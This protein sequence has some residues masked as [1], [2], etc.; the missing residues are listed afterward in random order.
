MAACLLSPL[1]FAQDDSAKVERYLSRLGLSEMRVRH[2]EREVQQGGESRDRAA[3]KL[4]DAY[5]A[6]L[7]DAAEDQPRFDRLKLQIDKLLLTSP[8]AGTPALQV[9]LLQAEFQRG[10]ALIT[11]WI[12]DPRDKQLLSRAADILGPLATQLESKG[13]ELS[14][15]VDKLA[16]GI[17]AIKSED[18]RRAADAE[19]LRL[20]AVV[21]RVTFYTGWSR[22]YLG[23]TKQESMSAQPE[24]A[25]A[26]ALFC[27]VLGVSDEKEYADVEDVSS[28]G[29]E[30]TWRARTALGL[31]LTE[32]GLGRPA[33]A[34]RCFSWLQHASAPAGLRDQGSFWQLQGLLNA[35]NL[36]GAAEFAA[37]K[38]E[39]LASPPTPGKNSLCIAAIRAG[40]AVDPAA[41]DAE[42]GKSLIAA[43]IRGLARLRQ[44]ET[45]S[46]LVAKHKLE[47]F[48]RKSASFYLAW[49]K[50]RGQFFAAEK[51][52]AAA[53]Y[54][55]AAVALAAALDSPD[56]GH[57][58]FA[59]AQCRYHLAWC[60]FRLDDFETAARLFREAAPVLVESERELA[61][62]AMW[63]EFACFQKLTETKKEKKYAASAVAALKALKRD[64]PDSE[65]AAKAELLIARLQQDLSPEEALAS[66]L[67]IKPTD[68][69]YAS[70]RLEI[71]QLQVQKWSKVKGDKSQ[72]P[73]AAKDALAAV[74][75]LLAAKGA[76]ADQKLRGALIGLQVVF[77]TAPVDEKR[78]AAWLEAATSAGEG[79]PAKSPLAAEF[80][81]R[82][83]QLAQKT[84]DKTAMNK[85]AAWIAANSAGSPYEM[86]ALVIVAR[87]ADDS[88]A[89]ATDGNRKE[90]QEEAA[91]VYSRLA[92]LVG[93]S[94]EAIKGVKNALAVNSKLAHYDEVL[95]RWKEAAARLDKIVVAMPSD[96]KYLRRSG[97][98]HFQAGEFAPALEQWRKLL[99]G[100][101]GGSDEWFEAKYHQLA[102]LA[103]TDRPS[104]VKVWK[105]FKLLFPQVKSA[106]WKD[107]FA[108]LDADLGKQP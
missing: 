105:Q 68:P 87:Q 83:L 93:E 25:A 32:T 74:E 19:L 63:M 4:A 59:A 92:A 5:A 91:D 51:S 67:A 99:G 72:A 29:L 45:L 22:Y 80:H 89:A 98:A 90:L 52:K 69:N 43:G 82:R 7:M 65:Q 64:F 104:A 86:P 61:V 41:K 8:A 97:I 10:E 96:K 75:T 49:L 94:P 50:G 39:T 102:C 71:A 55:A 53:D 84:G 70:A 44:F 37:K 13:K 42:T 3:R 20:Q 28:L 31:A 6:A 38:V 85:A 9:A 35:P 11:A 100:V 23:V 26:K 18:A 95:G 1:A 107:R 21:A 66:L 56:A 36:V 60:R 73:A 106:A 15:A 30:S 24:F 40:A 62:Q 12:E 34:E 76:S 79:L 88:V 47:D 46:Q 16:E 57:D 77:E 101:E 78:A 14:T 54:Q 48:Q 27:D 108:T 2:L 81:Y 17:D 58:L 103:K 33:A